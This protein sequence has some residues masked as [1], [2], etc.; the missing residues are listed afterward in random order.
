VVFGYTRGG[1][2]AEDA[3]SWIRVETIETAGGC[4]GDWPGSRFV[5]NMPVKQGLWRLVQQGL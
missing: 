4:G 5:T 1:V 3:R 2:A